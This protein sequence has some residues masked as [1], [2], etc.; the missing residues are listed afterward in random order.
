MNPSLSLLLA[1]LALATAQLV[2]KELPE[3]HPPLKWTQ[4]AAPGDCR[5]INGELTVDENGT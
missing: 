2:G 1:S 4:C 3:N 5:T